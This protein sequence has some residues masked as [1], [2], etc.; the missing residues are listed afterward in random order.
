MVK[1][2]L[3][4]FIVFFVMPSLAIADF[5]TWEDEKG[6]VHITDYPPPAKQGKKIKVR[7][8]EDIPKDFCIRPAKE[9]TAK[10]S[11]KD[12]VAQSENNEVIL[13]T[14]SWCPYC[15]KAR[16]FFASRNISFTE[17]DIERD[18]EAARRKKE[19][20]PRGGVPFAIINGKEIHGY[21]ESAYKNALR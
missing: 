18:K 8:D 12:K 21:S 17:Y 7:K 11:D 3:F 4:V 20:D 5:Y 15:T 1:Y 6:N 10:Q 2:I 19:L 14:T 16:D 9:Q 13:Y